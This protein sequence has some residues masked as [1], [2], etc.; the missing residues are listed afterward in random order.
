MSTS[1]SLRDLPLP[2]K[3]VASVFLL[4]VGAGYTSAM[5]Q[6]HM[7]DSKSGKP[8][9]TVE[10]VI[11]KYTGK[12]KYDP[13]HPPPTAVSRLESLIMSETVAISGSSMAAAFTTED[14][15][16]GDLKFSN[17]IKGKTP[18]QV[19]SIK[20]ERKG[21]QQVFK[22]WINTPEEARKKAYEA[23]RFEVPADQM[24]KAMTPAFKDGN[25]IKIKSIIDARCV[26]CHSKGG[27]KDTVPL[28]THEGLLKH[29]NAEKAAVSGDWVK[30]EEPISITK[31]TQ[32]THA[33]LLSF[34][35]LFS[36][37]GVIFAFSSYPTS[38]RC[39]LGP[40]VVLAVFADVSLWWLARLSDQCGPYFAMGII[41]TGGAAGLGLAAQIVL[42]L[43][44]MYGVKGKA[45]LVLMFLLAGG[46]AGLVWMNKI[47][48]AL[49]E[50]ESLQKPK[51]EPKKPTD[52]QTGSTKDAGKNNGNG[53]VNNVNGGNNNPKVEN[54]KPYKPVNELDR[55]LALPRLDEKG[56]PIP[57]N[58]LQFNGQDNGSMVPAYFEK[59]KAFKKLMDD[60]A[61]PQAAKDK[62]KSER[63][64]ELDATLA[65]I[66][67]AD[68][69]RKAAYDTNSL[70]VPTEL[71]GKVTPE[72]VKDGKVQIKSIIDTRC[73]ACHA[74]EKKQEDYPL[75]KYEE[76]AKYLQPLGQAETPAPAP[77]PAPAPKQNVNP[78]P[79]SKDD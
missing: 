71:I 58:Q 75:T 61:A 1:F 39:I 12:V 19:E 43:F 65:W 73:G 79:A 25:A 22:L 7:Q 42:S 16:K 50:K 62:L 74:P 2:V 53:N 11:R 13:T 5:V 23:D 56:Q 52:G 9:P 29:M 77:A 20:A 76:L 44:N 15:A 38:V 68:G 32:S 59:E 54:T 4:A 31:L 70:A 35:V 21:E 6:L 17:A 10:D 66:R 47:E 78:I 37:T 33:H 48:P 55:L 36:L 69:A 14:R 34:A 45:V 30:V 63:Q 18:E 67:S 51:D 26:N 27:D 3:V 60:P 49:K 8:M 57:A 24:P 40:W 28:D 72:F 41:A 64:A 46:L